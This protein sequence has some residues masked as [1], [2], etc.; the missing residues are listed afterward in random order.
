MAMRW[1]RPTIKNIMKDDNLGDWRIAVVTTLAEDVPA[2][3]IGG[4]SWKEV[5]GLYLTTSGAHPKDGDLSFIAPHPSALAFNIA[6]EYSKKAKELQRRLA[7]IS[8][9]ARGGSTQAISMANIPF[10]YDYFELVMI[11]I[12]FSFQAIET[13]LNHEIVHN[14]KSPIRVKRRNDK[15]ITYTPQEA[16]RNLST[17][18]KAAIVLPEI[19]QICTPKGKKPWEDFKKLNT[20]RDSTIHIK[21]KDIH[22]VS[23]IGSISENLFFNLLIDDPVYYP[24]YAFHLVEWFVKN[25]ELPRWFKLLAERENLTINNSP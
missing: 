12:T 25:K 14:A 3:F 15:W 23:K 10:L 13:F 9:I 11:A 2:A 22:Q 6:F 4:P 21:S 8:V 1:F 19:F 16:E 24:Q 17:E 20:A 5:D 7:K 18:E